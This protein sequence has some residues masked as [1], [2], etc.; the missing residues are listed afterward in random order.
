MIQ[1]LSNL[2]VDHRKSVYLVL[3]LLTLLCAVLFFQVPINTDM[4]KYLP[5]DSMMKMGIDKME[6]EF[7]D[8]EIAKTVR[9]MSAEFLK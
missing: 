2:V 1:K 4:T 3:T 8:S 7:P 6:E 5:D 9:V